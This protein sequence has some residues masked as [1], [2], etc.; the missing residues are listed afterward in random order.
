VFVTWAAFMV[1]EPLYARDVLHRPAS[2]FAFFQVAFGVGLVL[3]GLTLPR[4]G[5]RVAGVRPLAMAVL[6]S[7][8]TA[9]V[10]VGTHSI[11]AAY[12][13]VFFWGVDV[14]FFAAPSRTLLQRGAPTAAHGRVLALYRTAR[15]IADLAALPLGGLLAARVG[16]QHAGL[17][18]AAFAG[19]AGV[20]ALVVAPRIQRARPPATAPTA[21]SSSFRSSL[22]AT[23]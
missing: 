8:L 5:E 6:L 20:V 7:G 9:G 16:V 1:I 2:Q 22:P 12:A 23:P 14:A 17:F 10:Y 11:V 21:A 4:L 3:T 18:V 15:S 19:G 13:G